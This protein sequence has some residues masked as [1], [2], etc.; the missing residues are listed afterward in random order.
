MV[1]KKQDVIYRM[2]EYQTLVNRAQN[3]ETS[4]YPERAIANYK[5]A[6]KV[7][8]KDRL[9]LERLKSLGNNN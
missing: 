1:Y 9:V 4:N 5:Q 2:Q 7:K 6:L 8:P 3:F